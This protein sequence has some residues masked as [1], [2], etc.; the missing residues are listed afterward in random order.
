[1]TDPNSAADAR[2]RRRARLAS[3]TAV[4][5][6]VVAFFVWVYGYL[7]ADTFGMGEDLHCPSG[8]PSRPDL[9]PIRSACV[10][11]DGTAVNLIP[12]WV[13][14]LYF[15]CL[16]GAAILLCVTAWNGCRTRTERVSWLSVLGACSLGLAGVALGLW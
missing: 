1:M 11:P 9:F 10:H 5:C 3:C 7:H 6:L 15:A 16:G 14:P 8:T 4:C 12:A 13:D 2:R